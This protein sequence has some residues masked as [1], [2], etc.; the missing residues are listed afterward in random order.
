[1]NAEE[2]PKKEWLPV[3]EEEE[4]SPT[5]QGL[6]GLVK[7]GGLAELGRLPATVEY[8]AFVEL[9]RLVAEEKIEE[10]EVLMKFEGLLAVLGMVEFAGAEKLLD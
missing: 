9:G 5:V 6:L 8:V 10:L 3:V 4:G 7:F 2:L 1:M